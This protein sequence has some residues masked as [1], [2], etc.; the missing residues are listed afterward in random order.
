MSEPSW[1]RDAEQRMRSIL[2]RLPHALLIQGPGGWGEDR[3]AN[4]LAV[5]LMGLEPEAQARAVAHPDLRWLDAEDGA[6][7]IDAIRGVIDF[8]MHTPQLAGRKIAVIEDADRM[9]VN[10]A[11]ALLKSLEE[12]P[13]ES[14]IALTSGAPERLLPTIRSRCQRI[15][16]HPAPASA[17]AAW[18]AENGVDANA[19]RQLAVEYGGAP[20]AVLDA[21]QRGQEP[22]W[23]ALARVGRNSA[24]AAEMADSRR[25]ENL[26][27]LAGRWLRIVHD[28]LRRW[29]PQSAAPALAFADDL[30]KVR[31]S[32][33]LNSGLNRPMQLH[34]LLLLWCDLWPR[35]PAAA[36]FAGAA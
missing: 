11:N 21:A 14:F 13:A 25:D 6:I 33:L 20:Y 28:L 22:L 26:A 23:P 9:N 5:Q 35:I 12:P 32:A 7:K 36:N 16:V 34:R 1:L 24:A 31:E 10:A 15:D 27:D 17:V 30:A 8:L 2:G 4:A 19:G 29:P 3:I 18:L